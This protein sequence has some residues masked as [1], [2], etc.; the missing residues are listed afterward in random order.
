[1][2]F[3]QKLQEIMKINKITK[4]SLAKKLDVSPS[5]VK[6]WLSG[7]SSPNI[8]RIRQIADLF[9][10]STNYLLSD[11]E[12]CT[13]PNFNDEHMEAM[14]LQSFRDVSTSK[15]FAILRYVESIANDEQDTINGTGYAFAEIDKNK[16]E[17]LT[18]SEIKQMKELLKKFNEN[19]ITENNTEEEN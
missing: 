4:V 7:I 10:V 6:N 1:M 11:D 19:N 15:K 18:P 8:R 17:Y 12:S 2:A 16:Y 13:E 5:T 14:L 3:S 9:N